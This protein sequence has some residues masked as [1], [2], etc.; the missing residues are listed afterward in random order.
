MMITKTKTKTNP[1]QTKPDQTRPDQTK[2]NQTKPNQTKPN[3]A[4]TTK[5]PSK[6]TK[7]EKHSLVI[8]NVLILQEVKETLTKQLKVNPLIICLLTLPGGNTKH[9][10]K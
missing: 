7:E 1:N 6:T 4:A 2:P 10:I 8:P 5:K 3:Q 9:H